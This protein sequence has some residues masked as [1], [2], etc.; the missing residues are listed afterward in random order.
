MFRAL[1]ELKEKKMAV[2]SSIAGGRTHSV[3]VSAN[4]TL[5]VTL[6]K[7]FLPL[8]PQ[9]SQLLVSCD[10]ISISVSSF[11]KWLLP[12]SQDCMIMNMC[13]VT[14]I[15]WLAPWSLCNSFL[16]SV[17]V[18]GQDPSWGRSVCRGGGMVLVG[19]AGEKRSLST[20]RTQGADHWSPV[21]GRSCLGAGLGRIRPQ[22]PKLRLLTR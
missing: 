5:H 16:L 6:G 8:E 15:T 3:V 12:T 1:C 14:I 11:V 4:Y 10:S 22:N 21:K 7:F 9:F 20:S 17:P 2:W 18:L 19:P 13:L